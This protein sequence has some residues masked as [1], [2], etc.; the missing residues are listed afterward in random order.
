MTEM[1]NYIF[2]GIFTIEAI[3]KIV[4]LGRFYFKDN[5]NLFDLVVVIVTL[6]GII[7]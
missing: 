1:L 4:A 3:I 5:W 6:L 7:I 2:A